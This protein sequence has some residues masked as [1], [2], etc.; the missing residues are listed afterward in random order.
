MNKHKLLFAILPVL[1]TAPAFAQTYKGTGKGLD[2]LDESVVMD[3]LGGNNLTTLQKRDFDNFKVPAADQDKFATLPKLHLLENPVG[4]N[5]A[6]RRQLAVE[7]A[8]GFE[9][10]LAKANDAATLLDQANQLFTAG[11]LPDQAELEFFGE[12]PVGQAQ[13]KPVVETTRKMFAKAHDLAAT[14]LQTLGNKVKNAQQFA[15]M[16]PQFDRLRAAKAEAEFTGYMATYP[17]CLSLPR[18]DPQRKTLAKEAIDKYLKDLDAPDSGVQPT[19]RMQIGKLQL[20]AGDYDAAKTTLDSLVENPG[21]AIVPAPTLPDENNARY[22]SIVAEILSRKLPAAET[23]IDSLDQWETRAYLPTLS[24]PEQKQVKAALAMIKFRLYSAQSDLAAGEVQQKAANDK[25]ID[26][27][28]TLLKDQPGL[29]DL[30]FDQLVSRIPENPDLTAMNPL[31]LK[32]LKQQGIYEVQKKPDE[33]VDTKKLQRA[34]DAA[35]E[36]V[37]RKGQPGVADVDVEKSAYFIGYGYERLGD[38]KKAAGAFLDYCQNFNSNKDNADD[39][40]THAIKWIGVLRKENASDPDTRALYDRFLPLAINA[41]FNMKTFAFA[42][43]RLLK[44]EHK[45]AD[46]VKYFQMVPPTDKRY[47]EAQFLQL[48]SYALLL[49]DN[50]LPPDARKEIANN[51]L[52]LTKKVDA[53]PAAA[54]SPDDVATAR[55]YVKGADEIAADVSRSVLKEPAKTLEILTGFEDRIAGDKDAA[56]AHLYALQLRINAQ[57]DL[58]KVTDAT[59]L[60]FDLLAVDEAAGQNLMFAVSK[61]I[62]DDMQSAKSA[63]NI[64]EE[65]KL[66][67]DQAQ[68]SSVMLDWATKSKDPK[69]QKD[70]PSYR[71]FSADSKRKAAE[72]V[73]DPDVK[74]KQLVDALADYQALNKMLPDDSGAMEGIAYCQYDLGNYEEAIKFLS[75]L[76]TGKKVGEPFITEGTGEAAHETENVDFWQANYELINSMVQLS[77]KDPKDPKSAKYLQDAKSYVGVLFITYGQKTGGNAFHKEFEALR[78]AVGL[79]PFA[80]K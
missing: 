64:A 19:V 50:T 9:T 74:H 1:F 68:L 54:T 27:L 49:G 44:D 2:Q 16:R 78:P 43:A 37:S 17:L 23:D 79:A 80:A 65:K 33:K 42:Y 47:G 25:A 61:K 58:G 29:S 26:V 8:Q 51:I 67:L 14:E 73:D 63:G 56:A 72:L 4:L 10:Q 76:V 36:L 57:L 24:P 22:F 48:V 35:R 53:M 15:Q 55:G 38:N 52:E 7:V 70:L 45:Y 30:V 12:N 77:K 20:V 71:R 75:P 32:G 3:Y 59:K 11:V 6:K 39:A 46:A 69:V 34:I 13:L 18:D 62:N 60:L 31:V 5:V 21:K 40:M 41:P 28:A 66:S